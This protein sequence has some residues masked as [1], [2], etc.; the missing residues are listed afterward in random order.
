MGAVSVGPAMKLNEVTTLSD[1]LEGGGELTWGVLC[2]HLTAC[3][4]WPAVHLAEW[5]VPNWNNWWVI[6]G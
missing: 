4:L 3:H 1:G 5:W 2:L 6:T